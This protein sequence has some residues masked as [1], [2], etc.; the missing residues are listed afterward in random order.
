MAGGKED[1]WCFTKAQIENSPSRKCGIDA[2]KELSY[3]QQAA[4]YIQDMG[5][6][7]QVTQLCINTAIVY[8][9]RFFMFHSFTKFHRNEIAAA[10]LFLAAKVEE[11]PRKLEHVVSIAYRCLHRD[12]PSL[13]TKSE[14]YLEKAQE[15]VCNENILLQALGF[16]ITVD[17]PHTHVVKTC[18]LVRASKDLAQ[19]SYFLATN[20]L[21]LTSMCLAAKPTVVACVAIHLAC[22]WSSWEFP[23]SKEG[24]D[25]WSYVDRS[26]T[27]EILDDLTQ[28]FLNIIEKCP[29]RL[30]G[31][32]MTWKSDDSLDKLQDQYAVT[33]LSSFKDTRPS[34]PLLK[35]ERPDDHKRS[36]P[37]TSRASSPQKMKPPSDKP[38]VGHPSAAVGASHAEVTAGMRRSKSDA[39][40]VHSFKEYKEIKARQEAAAAAQQRTGVG[41]GHAKPIPHAAGSSRPQPE[42]P[43]MTMRIRQPIPEVCKSQPMHDARRPQPGPEVRKPLPLPQEVRKPSQPG[44]DLRKSQS[45]QD[46]RKLQSETEARKSQSTPEVHKHPTPEG[47]K[48]ATPEGRKRVT[49]EGRRQTT[50]EGRARREE[51]I[52]SPLIGKERCEVRLERIDSRDLSLSKSGRTDIKL[53]SDLKFE[54]PDIKQERLSTSVKQERP[55]RSFSS[56]KQD[57]LDGQPDR[58]PSISLKIEK[59]GEERS[60]KPV[61]MD[62]SEPEKLHEREPLVMRIP[63]VEQLTAEREK[64]QEKKERERRERHERK[65]LEREREKEKEK[66]K[67]GL[68]LKI[69]IGGLQPE[70]Q[71]EGGMNRSASS[72]DVRTHKLNM[73]SQ[74]MPARHHHHHHHGHHH[75]QSSIRHSTSSSDLKLKIN[76]S[77]LQ[78]PPPGA[79]P[80]PPGTESPGQRK[81][82]L[83]IRINKHD[84]KQKSSSSR[85]RPRS[86]S[87]GHH[88]K[89]SRRETF[90]P[91]KPS[92]SN[93]M[94]R[95]IQDALGGDHPN[96]SGDPDPALPPQSDQASVGHVQLQDT[97]IQRQLIDLSKRQIT[98]QRHVLS[99]QPSLPPL[100]AAPPMPD[101]P[102]LPQPPL[103]PPIPT[104]PPPPSPPLPPSQ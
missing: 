73:D 21:H 47:R 45:V 49:P 89:H 27:L 85:K 78:P 63:V 60:A 90:S 40:L 87:A 57:R 55:D 31:K 48:Q 13:D 62:T 23:K 42:I 51:Q 71:Q 1:R 83:G 32:I 93:M 100:Q 22:K 91:P 33:A 15:L 38:D 30:K 2:E 84:L 28:D 97:L 36:E 58:L 18:Q 26:V 96:G 98:Y 34:K 12:Q 52:K 70:I 104:E 68:K 41:N 53:D 16:D 24:K 67:E 103:P 95:S 88:S 102:P 6:R 46:V 77:K 75:D 74:Q 5:Q 50:P 81:E 10:C 11:Q 92:A 80:P 65:R 94:N 37:G 72:V 17:H 59:H 20:S 69:K 64:K 19:T 7:L 79:T 35:D 76:T 82:L 9:H 39:S 29:S 8:M 86:P 54:R 44:P 99:R 56:T 4:N 43:P 25:W 101:H 3:R 61:K 14:K 66:E